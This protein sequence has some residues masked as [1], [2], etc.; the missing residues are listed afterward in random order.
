[1]A[2]SAGRGRRSLA[3]WGLDWLLIRAGRLGRDIVLFG[4]QRTAV[5]QFRQGLPG[6]YGR[7]R[8]AVRRSGRGRPGYIAAEIHNEMRRDPK[9]YR[10]HPTE[11]FVAEETALSKY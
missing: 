2:A 4:R 10:L 5:R 1:M 11:Q 8:T 3:V 6:Y 7:Q 9:S